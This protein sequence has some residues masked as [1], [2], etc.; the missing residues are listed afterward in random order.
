MADIPIPKPLNQNPDVVVI[1]AG[2]AGLTHAFC[3]KHAGKSVVVL[4]KDN[5]VGGVIKSESQDGFLLEFGPSTVLPNE[6]LLK[7]IDDLD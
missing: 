1:G 4:E 6:S 5:R 3:A 2:L 7:L